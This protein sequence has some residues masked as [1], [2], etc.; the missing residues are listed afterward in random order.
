M[1]PAV[2]SVASAGFA[3]LLKRRGSALKDKYD[4]ALDDLAGGLFMGPPGAQGAGITS[5]TGLEPELILG[6]RQNLHTHHA[7]AP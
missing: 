4:E 1:W 5:G 2:A 6:S 7:G 3:L